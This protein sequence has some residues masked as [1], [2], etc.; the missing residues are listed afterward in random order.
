LRANPLI[1][2]TESV[3][4][5]TDSGLIGLAFHPDYAANGLMYIHYTDEEDRNRIVEYIVD[6]LTAM[7]VDH[8]PRQILTI[9]RPVGGYHGG[10]ML[11]FGPDGYLYVALGD[12]GAYQA[13]EVI[14][15]EDLRDPEGY[16]QDPDALLGGILRIDVDSGSHYAIPAVNAFGDREANETF[17][18]GLR[19]PYRFWI[20]HPTDRMFIGDVGQGT[21]EEINTV[22]LGTSGINFG[23]DITEGTSCYLLRSEFVAECDRSGLTDPILTYRNSGAISPLI[24]GGGCAVILGPV[25]RGN[26]IPSLDGTL[27][28]ADFCSNWIGSLRYVDERVVDQMIWELAEGHS[29]GTLLSFGVDSEGEMYLL[30]SA[31]GI[32]YKILPE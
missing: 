12:G 13:I 6:P 31:G 29:L 18:Y 4:S 20:D 3:Y 17:A 7:L 24:T 22:E 25:Y 16:A 21:W 2:I 11:Q 5:G 1:D 8:S 15:G 19:N 27:F 14:E 32:I 10:G 28:Y 9:A 26:E 30:T 23:W